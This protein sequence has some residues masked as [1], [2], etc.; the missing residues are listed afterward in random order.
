MNHLNEIA[1]HTGTRV[2]DWIALECPQSRCG[3]DYAFRHKLSGMEVYVNDDQGAVKIKYPEPEGDESLPRWADN[4]RD[5]DEVGSS[6]YHALI[7]LLANAVRI[8]NVGGDGIDE[9]ATISEDARDHMLGML[10]EVISHARVMK[11]SLKRLQ[12]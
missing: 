9:A 8:E 10:D 11:R 2:A 4:F 5:A 12:Y 1:R 7:E 6:E 3:D